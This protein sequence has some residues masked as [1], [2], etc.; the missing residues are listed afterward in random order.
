MNKIL[1]FI[2]LQE[3]QEF[4]AM[5]IINGI[6]QGCFILLLF[7]SLENFIGKYSKIIKHNFYK[8]CLIIVI[9]ISLFA[10]L[11]FEKLDFNLTN[12]V[13]K[14]HFESNWVLWIN[15][16]WG[17]GVMF[18]FIRLF[19]SHYFIAN[20]LKKSSDVFPDRWK[21]I[22]DN[23]KEKVINH[24]HILMRHS[25]SIHSAFVTGILKPVIIFPTCWIN[26]LNEKEAE[27]IILHE[28]SHL[29]YKDH[30]FN[31]ICSF[32]EIIFFYNP[33]IH[34]IVR[35]IKLQR[36]ICSDQL[37]L[38]FQPKPLEYASLLVKIG[39]NK[40]VRN[41]IPF[42]SIKNQL[43]IRVKEIL[44]VQH[45]KEIQIKNFIVPLILLIVSFLFM[46]TI[47]P[48]ESEIC[49]K[50]DPI[51]KE[52]NTS[53][54]KPLTNLLIHPP[55]IKIR[56]ERVFIK[57]QESKQ[58]V[59]RFEIV[60]I[61]NPQPIEIKT[62]NFITSESYWTEDEFRLLNSRALF[63]SHDILNNLPIK[64]EKDTNN[65]VIVINSRKFNSR[66]TSSYVK[67]IS[68]DQFHYLERETKSYD[69]NNPKIVQYI[70]IKDATKTVL[71]YSANQLNFNQFS[72]SN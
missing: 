60:E 34:I 58:E 30:Y 37:V 7:L 72:N 56:Q 27:C 16:M 20:L 6:W 29:K 28:L 50:N 35:K 22:F 39:E 49:L 19:L 25:E 68:D 57:P 51:T 66:P 18:L 32:A 9:L 43:T 1:E 45:K 70:I 69:F 41:S 44:Q 48:R 62:E 33:A 15:L 2:D 11:I 59:S 64:E 8:S 71:S 10:N 4:L 36:E 40:Q 3:V 53:K 61:N 14:L 65:F 17:T 47:D 67:R 63:A 26:Q 31:M 24:A 42:G 55:R 12:Q 54:N 23:C 46:H 13:V 5:S 52:V 38:N 21:K